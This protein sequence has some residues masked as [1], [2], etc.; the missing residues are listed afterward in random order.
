L[1][2][3]DLADEGGRAQPFLDAK[4]ILELGLGDQAVLDQEI[5]EELVGG[6]R[7]RVRANSV[8]NYLERVRH[9]A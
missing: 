8:G 2:D 9:L 6:R 4:G 1:V 3:Q 7:L 5:S